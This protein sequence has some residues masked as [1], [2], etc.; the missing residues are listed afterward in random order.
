MPWLSQNSYPLPQEDLLS[1]TFD[2]RTYDPDKPVYIDLENPSRTISWRQG[3][4][5]VRKLVAGFRKAGLKRGDCVTITSFNDLLYS[6]CFL[7]IIGAGG[8]FS[9]SNPAYKPMEVRHHIRTAQVKWFI[10]EPELLDSIL[11][12]A[13]AEGIPKANVFVF[14]THGQSVPEGF[15]SWE[16]LL[17]QGEDDWDRFTNLE[18]CKST[19]IARLTTSGTTGPPKMAV[20]SVYNATSWG[21]M[22]NEH[23]PPPFEVSIRLFIDQLLTFTASK[24]LSIAHVPRSYGPS[25]PCLSFQEWQRR[26]YY[27]A[28]RTGAIPRSDREIPDQCSRD[29]AS[30]RY[31]H[32]YVST[33]PQVLPEVHTESRLRRCSFGQGL[34]VAIQ[35][36]LRSGRNVH[37]GLWND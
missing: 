12:T 33:A 20:Q 29:S 11:D 7:G 9:G 28:I 25:R 18:T 30:S 16:W 19:H 13:L 26:I 24:H 21:T 32:H 8:V 31:F 2:H 36:A 17:E 1:W 4:S 23:K 15:R 35:G 27:A 14:N 6:M 5:M 22:M 3:R 10:V 34:P 37:S